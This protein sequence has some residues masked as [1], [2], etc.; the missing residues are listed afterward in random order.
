MPMNKRA[1]QCAHISCL[2]AVMAL[3]ACEEKAHPPCSY[4]GVGDVAPSAGCLVIQGDRL[5]LVETAGG[6]FG[7]PAG[8]VDRGE[9]AQC[10]AE[11]E[12]WEETGVI[13]TV[14][15]LYHRFDNGFHL[16]RCT[17]MALQTINVER[18]LEV[19][20]A[21]YYPVSRFEALNW[22]FPEQMPMMKSA[23]LESTTRE[24]SKENL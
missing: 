7:P 9:S 17:P 20:S 5:L 2:M 16:Y 6:Q 18:P 13:V 24:S 4:E 8:S 23:V 22:R 11:R 19:Q 21:D 12:T 10:G 14:G 1:R 3:P 15:E